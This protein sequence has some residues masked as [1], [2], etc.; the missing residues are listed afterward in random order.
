MN[1][2]RWIA[3]YIYTNM[4]RVVVSAKSEEDGLFRRRLVLYDMS[5]C[6]VLGDGFGLRGTSGDFGEFLACGFGT[7]IER[8]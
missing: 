8:R 7:E 5:R 2:Q 4:Q 3:E 1:R 6:L